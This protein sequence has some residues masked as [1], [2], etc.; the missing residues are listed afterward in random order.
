MTDENKTE[1]TDKKEE[2]SKNYEPGPRG[3][4]GVATAAKKIKQLWHER[5][6]RLVDANDRHNP[7]KKLWVAGR[8]TPSLKAF[9]RLLLKDETHGQVAKDWFDHKAGSLNEKRSEKN[10]ARIAL[11]KQATKAAKRKKSQGKQPKAAA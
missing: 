8:D 10:V 2:A 11:E 3:E 1:K 5:H 6:F 7:R 9:A 4:L